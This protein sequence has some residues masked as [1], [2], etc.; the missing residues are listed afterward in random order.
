[1][2]RETRRW[3][4]TSSTG[5]SRGYRVRAPPRRRA[6][7][8]CG[9]AA[10]AA[11]GPRPPARQAL[12]A[13]QVEQPDLRASVLV[14]AFAPLVHGHVEP[15]ESAVD[16]AHLLPTGTPLAPLGRGD[17][18]PGRGKCR[19]RAGEVHLVHLA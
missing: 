16:G 1:M 13:R 7:G 4:S 3:R 6:P 12:V 11:A 14:G 18:R 15:T 19:L 8:R 9:P 10:G 2:R 5:S 17:E